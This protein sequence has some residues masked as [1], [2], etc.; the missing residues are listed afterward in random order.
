VTEDAFR[1]D[2]RV[3]AS[4]YRQRFSCGDLEFKRRMWRVLCE[5]YFQQYVAPTDTV[6]DLGAG[7]CEFINAIRAGRK[8]AVDMNPETALYARDAEFIL[9]PS[10]DL[11]PVA[12]DTVDLLFCSNLLEHLPDKAAVLKSLVECRRVLRPAGTL[13]VLQPNIRY[14][15]G[16]YWDYFDHHT[17]LTHVSVVEALGLAGFV[18]RRVVPRFLP[19]TVKNTRV[20][21]STLLLRAYLRLPIIW[22]LFGRQM[23]IVAEARQGPPD[24]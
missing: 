8:I 19:Y 2:E 16:R 14:L 17:P 24:E 21:R 20:L 3:L 10:T 12:A 15:P 4:L 5:R 6:L 9:A 13:L 18:S 11:S 23:L 22:P 1:D 7:S